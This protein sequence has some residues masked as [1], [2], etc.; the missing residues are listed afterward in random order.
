MLIRIVYVAKVVLPVL[1]GS[2]IDVVEY[3]DMYRGD[4]AS[5]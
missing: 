2:F 4:K 1:D 3:P 5:V